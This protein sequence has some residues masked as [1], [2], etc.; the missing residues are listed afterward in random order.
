MN[1]STHFF[2]VHDLLTQF[3]A[4]FDDTV[5]DRFNKSREAE[6]QVEARYVLA[7]KQRVLYDIVNKSNNITLPVVSIEV[8][9]VSRD[10]ARVFNKIEDVYSP[11]ND[12]VP[13][14]RHVRMPPPVPVNVSVT[15]SILCKYMTDADQIVSNFA[16][17]TNPYIVISHE[18]PVS[19]DDENADKY[20][21]RTNVVWDGDIAYSS[22]TSISHSD[23]YRVSLDTS[24]VIK[25][26]L[27]KPVV[28]PIG[29]I[30]KID[31]NFHSVDAINK[32]YDLAD[33]QALDE[34]YGVNDR[35]FTDTVTVSAQPTIT[36]LL[37]S[38]SGSTI[39]LISD[40][41]IV[42]DK[43]NIFIIEG[44]RFDYNN[45]FYL[46]SNVDS[47]YSNYVEVETALSP[48]ISAYQI[49]TDQI[50]VISD[51]LVTINFPISSFST[52]GNFTL[53]IANSA[54]WDTSYNSSGSILTIN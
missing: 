16:V 51:N 30:F 14:K 32:V 22:P 6:E 20:E 27:Y 48:T 36:S 8:T 4:A 33:W 31:A 26:W 35:L 47:F 50:A 54:G 44:K 28:N 39:R 46:S 52:P 17:Y 23:K 11:Y 19:L 10:P 5:I 34:V 24:F 25:G 2:E 45:T 15:M 42:T 29:T 18:F 21:V 37:Y 13:A 40:T 53:V 1:N 9:N 3:I 49:P 7:P 12:N 38:T 41:E 43:S